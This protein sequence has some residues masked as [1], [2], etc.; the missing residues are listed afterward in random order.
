MTKSICD[1]NAGNS[2]AMPAPRCPPSDGRYRE[3]NMTN[4]EL[5][6][7][8]ESGTIAADSF[9]H[10]DHVRLAYAYLNLHPPLEALERFTAALKRYADTINKPGLYHE[11]ITHAY[12]FLIRERMSRSSAGDWNEFISQNSDLLVSRNGALRRYYHSETLQSDLARAIFILPD[13]LL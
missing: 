2:S 10:S 1:A 13:K 7:R 5:I 11:T 9:H 6:D 4:Q 12:F 8:L 3:N